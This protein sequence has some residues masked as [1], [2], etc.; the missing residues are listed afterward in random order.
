MRVPPLAVTRRN[1]RRDIPFQGWPAAG[2]LVTPQ[3]S[4]Y[5]AVTMPEVGVYLFRLEST[6]PV[7]KSVNVAMNGTV[8]ALEPCV[9]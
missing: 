3:G 6:L 4:I 8:D 9:T 7:L 2:K 5:I 1:E